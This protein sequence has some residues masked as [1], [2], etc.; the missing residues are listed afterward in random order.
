MAIRATCG[1]CNS[2]FNA[3]DE[4]AGKR[5][6]CPKCKS[7]MTIGEAPKRKAP[8]APAARKPAKS[9]PAAIDPM[10]ALLA[11]ANIGQDVQSGPICPNCAAYV[12]PGSVLCID[13]GFNLET[14]KQVR[15]SVDKGGS[16]AGLSDAEKIMQKA[17]A[18]LD[19]MPIGSEDQDFGDGGESFVIAGVAMVVL[20]VL[21]AV[22]VA[23]ILSMDQISQYINSGGISVIASSILWLAM[24]FWLTTIAFKAGQKHGVACLASLG[25]Y[26]PI[27]GLMQGKA[28][29][30]P[31]IIMLV[32]LVVGG[33]SGAYVYYNG[34]GPVAG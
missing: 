25:L 33:G 32:T 5:V 18:D 21:V 3:R 28:L 9:Q 10:E 13:C 15:T 29:L 12:T 6:K 23:I 7:S 26:C 1:S 31:S 11:E 19:D 2:S 24:M 27:F 14:G 4:L 22:G 16:D 34:F 17:E 20:G 30:L 8:A